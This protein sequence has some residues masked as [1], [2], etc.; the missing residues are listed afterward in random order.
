MQATV[1]VDIPT[2]QRELVLGGQAH[3]TLARLSTVKVIV[4]LTGS[5]DSTDSWSVE[6]LDGQPLVKLNLAISALVESYMTIEPLLRLLER[7]LSRMPLSRMS[8][9]Q[10]QSLSCVMSGGAIRVSDRSGAL[11][12]LPSVLTT[13]TLPLA[14]ACSIVTTSISMSRPLTLARMDTTF[15]SISRKKFWLTIGSVL[16]KSLGMLCSLGGCTGGQRC[17]GIVRAVWTSAGDLLVLRDAENDEFGRLDRCDA[18]LDDQQPLVD[19][20]RR[21]RLGVALDVEGLV[22]RLAEKRSGTPQS[23]QEGVQCPLDALP[24]GDVVRLEDGPLGALQNRRLDHVE[25]PPHIDVA[26]VRIAGQGA[27]APDPDAAGTERPD[28]VDADRVQHG[29]FVLRDAVRHI[30]AAADG[31]VGRRLPHS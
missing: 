4:S 16:I 25:Q 10:P 26:P 21:I 3:F 23:A 8:L 7:S 17:G 5:F 30:Q 22:N 19:R 9:N 12:A 14:P 1:P 6:I 27:G 15:P 2:R 20:L 13:W 31:V 28:A 29:L 18:D 11:F 24:Q